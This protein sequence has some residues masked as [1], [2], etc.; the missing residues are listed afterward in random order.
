[1]LAD[2]KKDPAWYAG[3]LVKRV[4]RVFTMTTPVRL[5]WPTGWLDLPWHAALL[6]PLAAVLALFR[7]RFL[8]GLSL[9]TFPTTT[10]ALLVYSDL[11]TT[12][13]GVYHQV[14]FAVL[15][16]VVL[17]HAVFWADRALRRRRAH[18][19]LPASRSDDEPVDIPAAPLGMSEVT[20]S[21]HAAAPTASEAV[22]S[23][24]LTASTA[25]RGDGDLPREREAKTEINDG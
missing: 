5:S 19:S 20:A 11:G 15:A 7:S 25:T 1:M 13:Y 9:F 14:A 17:G 10:T 2:I 3:V 16:S 23:E 6:L 24:A 12:Y 18:V 21:E 8:L 4:H 22:A